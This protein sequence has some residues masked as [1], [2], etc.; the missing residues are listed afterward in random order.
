MDEKD[1]KSWGERKK[2]FGRKDRN[3]RERS[4]E[5][6]TTLPIFALFLFDYLVGNLKR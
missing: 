3:R 2:G 5:E 6:E 1:L 4:C